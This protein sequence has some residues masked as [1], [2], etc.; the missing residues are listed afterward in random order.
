MLN[1]KKAK[2]RHASVKFP[3]VTHTDNE[4]LTCKSTR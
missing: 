1:K 2:E 3:E 4:F